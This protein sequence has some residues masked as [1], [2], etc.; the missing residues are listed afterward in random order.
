MKVKA[1]HADRGEQPAH[2]K[3]QQIDGV[4]EALVNIRERHICHGRKLYG[5]SEGQQRNDVGA[6][7][8]TGPGIV[9]HD[10]ET[11]VLVVCVLIML[12][13]R[14]RYGAIESSTTDLKNSGIAP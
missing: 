8:C 6:L 13:L 12:S 1:E 14:V 2:F 7:L 5:K 3:I 4:E 11:L 10:N 9:T